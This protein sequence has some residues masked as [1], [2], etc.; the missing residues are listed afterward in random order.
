MNPSNIVNDIAISFHSTEKKKSETQ[1]NKQTHL[2]LLSDKPQ[3]KP[4]V[5][6]ADGQ[7]IFLQHPHL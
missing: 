3:V 4:Q 7:N 1:N 2:P 5:F 6:T